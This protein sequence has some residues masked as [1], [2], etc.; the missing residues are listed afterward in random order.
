MKTIDEINNGGDGQIQMSNK[1]IQLC[2]VVKIF[3]A[4]KILDISKIER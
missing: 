4:P 1:V 3:R 2:S